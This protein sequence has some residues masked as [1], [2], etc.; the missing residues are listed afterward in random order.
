MIHFCDDM[1]FRGSAYA[2]RTGAVKVQRKN[3]EDKKKRVLT[4][5]VDGKGPGMMSCFF[6]FVFSHFYTTT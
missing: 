6:V 1:P 4:H 2:Q 5:D 3:K